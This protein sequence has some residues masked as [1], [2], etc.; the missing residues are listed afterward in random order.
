M[1]V[2]SQRPPPGRS[3]TRREAADLIASLIRQNKI[4][5]WR[6]NGVRFRRMPGT[7]NVLRIVRTDWKLPHVY[8]YI[9]SRR[10]PTVQDISG[11]MDTENSSLFI[12]NGY[13]YF[14]NVQFGHIFSPYISL[15]ERLG[16]QVI[17]AGREC[18]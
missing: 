8:T 6:T 17:F 10:E 14:A 5:L 7:F 12:T 9:I 3:S 1:F 4:A 2:N 18:F 13:A 16:R 15:D 11:K